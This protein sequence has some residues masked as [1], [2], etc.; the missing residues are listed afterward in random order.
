MLYLAE[1]QKE[2]FMAGIAEKWIFGKISL[3][4][5]YYIIIY[6]II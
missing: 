5:N 3:Y 4:I 2:K 6:I 1:S